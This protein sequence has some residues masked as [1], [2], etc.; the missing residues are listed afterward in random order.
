MNI[1]N[2]IPR[3]AIDIFILAVVIGYAIA[4]IKEGRGKN[5]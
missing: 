1:S 5:A 4:R 2:I 3:L